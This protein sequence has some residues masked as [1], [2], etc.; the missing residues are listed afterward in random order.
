MKQRPAQPPLHIRTSQTKVSPGLKN[1]T[2]FLNNLSSLSQPSVETH[3]HP[4]HCIPH[5]PV[6]RWRSSSFANQPPTTIIKPLSTSQPPKRP[7]SGP[8]PLSSPGPSPTPSPSQSLNLRTSLGPL[9]SRP[10]QFVTTPANSRTT[11]GVT[12]PPSTNIPRPPQGALYKRAQSV[13]VTSHVS[14]EA[15]RLKL[16]ERATKARLYLLHQSG[17]NRFLIGGDAPDSRFHVT[18]GPQVRLASHVTCIERFYFWH[19]CFDCVA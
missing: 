17:P 3:V 8:D 16:I 11:Q 18:I 4:G 2:R 19:N 9:P 13:G 14:A 15:A 12:P 10:P 6:R 7:G 1:Y 5:P